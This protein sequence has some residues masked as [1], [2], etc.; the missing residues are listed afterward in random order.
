M[1]ELADEIR[2]STKRAGRLRQA[3][4]AKAF[5]DELGAQDPNDEP[6]GVLLER[7]RAQRGRSATVSSSARR[8]R[9]RT[10]QLA[11]QSD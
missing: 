4:L 9:S 8:T 3:I 1:V 2:K 7:I 5:S 6:A 11:L 10:S